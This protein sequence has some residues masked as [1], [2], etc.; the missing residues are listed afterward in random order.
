ML[1]TKISATSAALQDV[2]LNKVAY[3]VHQSGLFL[4]Q[5]ER[6]CMVQK[7]TITYNHLR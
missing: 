6:E 5:L 1:R 3:S 2:S 7:T 4:L